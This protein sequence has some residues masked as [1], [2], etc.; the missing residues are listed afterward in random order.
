MDS[1]KLQSFLSE[2]HQL[3]PS[4]VA[5]QETG[6]GLALAPRWIWDSLDKVRERRRLDMLKAWRRKINSEIAS[7]NGDCGKSIAAEGHREI[8]SSGGQ[9]GRQAPRPDGLLQG[10]GTRGSWAAKLSMS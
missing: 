5:V 7:L 6:A 1:S 8:Q 4:A 3:T 2:A 9:L 10:P